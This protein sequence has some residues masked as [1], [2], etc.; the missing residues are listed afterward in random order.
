MMTAVGDILPPSRTSFEV[1]VAAGMS[2]TLP[3]PLRQ[4]MNPLEAPESFLPFLAAH[5]SVDLWYS[6]WPLSR[7]RMMIA[8]AIPLAR[9]KGTR[10]AAIDFLAYVDG[11]LVDAL[12]HP[13]RFAMGRGIVG[14]TPIGHPPF[15]A[16]YLVKVETVK[17]PRACVLGRGIIGRSIIKASARVPLGRCLEALKV[18]KAP[19]TQIRV[20]F[21][22]MRP[23]TFGD[24]FTFSD[25]LTFGRYVDRTVLS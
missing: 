9:M 25:G 4:V 11:A 22:H 6:D 1:A 15:M 21:A 19:E 12:A 23:V 13:T 20:D 3:V 18:A 8:N 14:R 5:F 24:G 10:Q 7:K 16:R 2:D 17:E